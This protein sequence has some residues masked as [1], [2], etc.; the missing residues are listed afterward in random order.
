MP[1]R[2]R[3][4]RGSPRDGA[5]TGT[6][7]AAGL[8]IATGEIHMDGFARAYPAEAQWLRDHSTDFAES[9][10]RRIRS[11]GILT[12]GQLTAL[13]RC[14]APAPAA[15]AVDVAKIE[16][17]FAAARERGVKHP[18]LRLADFKFTDGGPSTLHAGAV[19]VREGGLY[20][21]KVLQGQFHPNGNCAPDKRAKVVAAIADPHAAA[22]AYGQRT[23]ACAV[24]GRPLV[25]TAS[26]DL[27][28]GPVCKEKMGW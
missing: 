20:L 3:A 8:A 26:V 22:I 1:P 16:E 25:V 15:A 19:F 6:T 10:K 17:A 18:K 12:P 9:L 28:I 23:G 4:F 27:G 5:T 21:G 14:A 24:C 13:V 7:A 2:Y 11:G